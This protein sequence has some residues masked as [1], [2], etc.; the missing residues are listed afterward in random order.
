LKA[1]KCR[2]FA[3]AIDSRSFFAA[4][5]RGAAQPPVPITVASP[6]ANPAVSSVRLES[7]GPS[8]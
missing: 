3:F 2:R 8:D 4:V 5:R 7:G 6:A 1:I